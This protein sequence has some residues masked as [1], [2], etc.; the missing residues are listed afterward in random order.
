[1]SF[2]VEVSF[3]V[4]EREWDEYLSKSPFANAFQM[5]Y[6]YKPDSI[7]LNSKQ[8]FIKVLNDSGKL[9]GQLSGVLNFNDSSY[10]SNPVLKSFI[11]HFHLGSYL[12]WNQ[13]PI[14]HDLN[15]HEEICIQI[16]TSLNN[17]CKKYHVVRIKGSTPPLDPN[18]SKNIFL[19]TNFSFTPWKNYIISIP[20]EL[21]NYF[22]S[23]SKSVRYDIR[24]GEKNNLTFE[25]AQTFDDVKDFTRL[26]FHKNDNAEE[27]IKNGLKLSSKTWDLLYKNNIRIAFLARL[28]NRLIG[29]INAVLFNKILT[30]TTVINSSNKSFQAGSFL[31]WNSIKWALEN[32]CTHVDLSGAN[33]NPISKKE[34]QIDFYKSKWGGEEYP[35]FI[36]SKVFSKKKYRLAR[37]LK[38]LK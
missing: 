31:T 1:M 6:Y 33:P 14:I 23:L 4:E 13:G 36:V 16:F 22:D 35:M 28:N 15:N 3:E 2:K 12:T 38:R 9:V 26:K 29:G 25:I 34:K 37:F 24:K 20:K 10:F 17:L 30:I 11:N 21:K 27:I 7:T 5:S 19:Q 18:F 32:D 8:I